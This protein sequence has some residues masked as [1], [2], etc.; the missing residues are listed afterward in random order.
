MDNEFRCAFFTDEYESTV[1][2]YRDLLEFQ[3]GESW[4]RAP[5]DK[6]TIFLAG[7]GMIEVLTKPGHERSWVWSK[8]KPRG[9]AIVIELDDVDA[10]YARILEK[11][12]VVAASIA[13]WEW[14]HRSFR[15]E[16][17][18]G[19]TLY[20]YSEIEGVHK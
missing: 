15:I 2:F 5:D 1:S 4:N 13:D 10:F 6:G 8:E 7:S 9:F 18:N 3:V 12:I 11:E 19:V 20:F 14:G 16:D 17:P